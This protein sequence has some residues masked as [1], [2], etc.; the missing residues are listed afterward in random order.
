MTTK[1]LIREQEEWIASRHYEIYR[2]P[3]MAEAIRKA[4]LDRLKMLKAE[5][6]KRG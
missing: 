3:E 6:A 4:D 5:V 2:D 1:T